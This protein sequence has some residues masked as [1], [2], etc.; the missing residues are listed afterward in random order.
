MI[1]NTHF[2]W[3]LD[4]LKPTFFTYSVRGWVKLV[5]FDHTLNV[6]MFQTKRVSVWLLLRA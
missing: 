3:V 2:T 5:T 4:F 1:L 6:V